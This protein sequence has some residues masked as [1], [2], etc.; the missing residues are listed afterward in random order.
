MRAAR[1]NDE[2]PIRCSIDPNPVLLQPISRRCLSRAQSAG[3]AILKN[4]DRLKQHTWQKESERDEPRRKKSSHAAPN[5]SAAPP[6]RDGVRRSDGR[7]AGC[8]LRSSDCRSADVLRGVG[9]GGRLNCGRDERLL[10]RLDFSLHL[11][12]RCFVSHGRALF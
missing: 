6:V 10:S 7:H 8:G 4:S 9:P 3:Y 2:K 12:H 11:F 1:V 5:K